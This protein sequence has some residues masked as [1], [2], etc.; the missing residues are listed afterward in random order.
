MRNDVY[1]AGHILYPVVD[2]L[3]FVA[4]ILHVILDIFYLPLHV[5]H[6]I[7]DAHHV[8]VDIVCQL[9]R[10]RRCHLCLFLCQPV[11]PLQAIL[12]VCVPQQLP[13][14]LFCTD[15][16]VKSSF[17]NLHSIDSLNRPRFTSFVAIARMA[18]TSTIISTIMSIIAVVGV[19]PVYISSRWKKRSIRFKMSTSLSRLALASLAAWRRCQNRFHK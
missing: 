3:N 14:I 18:S 1:I 8:S 7:I 13:E 17:V 9:Q 6:S 11:Q 10:L 5:P 19:I 15:V 12:D 16:S 4:N 2:I